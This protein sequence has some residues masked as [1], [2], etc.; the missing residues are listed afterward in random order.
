MANGINVP[1][2]VGNVGQAH[3]PAWHV[4]RRG[5]AV[6]EQPAQNQPAEKKWTVGRI[7]LAGI[8]LV[9]LG[10]AAYWITYALLLN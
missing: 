7:V 10:L 1:R 9:A 5:G 6:S 2:P 3:A 4:D 8:G